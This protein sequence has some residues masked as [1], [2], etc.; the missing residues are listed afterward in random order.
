[1]VQ[2]LVEIGLAEVDAWHCVHAVQ[3]CDSFV[4]LHWG[5]GNVVPTADPLWAIQPDQMAAAAVQGA[6]WDALD[7]GQW[8]YL[9]RLDWCAAQLQEL[10]RELQALESALRSR[11]AS[12]G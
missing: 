5:S 9:R 7:A 11:D 6:A 4:V 2:V 1:M 10:H 3:R 12:L 8:Q